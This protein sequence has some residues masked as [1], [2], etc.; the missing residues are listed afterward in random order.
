MTEL[1]INKLPSPT[2]N[3]LKVNE[4]V[5]NWDTPA[6]KAAVDINADEIVS[7]VGGEQT[8]ECSDINYAAVTVKLRER[9]GSVRINITDEGESRAAALSL[10]SE[11]DLTAFLNI[12]GSGSLIVDV[13]A[14][15]QSSAKIRL[16]INQT[17]SH[18]G[19]LVMRMNTDVLSGGTFEILSFFPGTSGTFV[20]NNVRLIG[21]EAILKSKTAYIAGEGEKLDLNYTA[22]QIGKRTHSDI[23]LRGA[24]DGTGEKIFRGTIDFKQ[25]SG[26]S[27]GSESENVLLLSDDVVNKTLPIILCSEEDISGIHG[28]TIGD[29]SDEELIYFASR[30]FSKEQ[31]LKMLKN[32][33][34]EDFCRDAN[35]PQT[36][37]LAVKRTVSKV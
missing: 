30:G 8:D 35:D 15:V 21:N 31:V 25:G 6:G 14:K 7:A 28:A 16:I 32:S 18:S 24:L 19:R 23:K 27:V 33:I 13:N 20:D 12:G 34:C 2:W 3:F 9:S 17:T 29:L 4:A 1:R 22:D 37:E 36:E 26:G 5:I 11:G 10:V